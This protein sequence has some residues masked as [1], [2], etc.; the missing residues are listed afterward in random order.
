MLVVPTE[1]LPINDST[2]GMKYPNDTPKT[3]AKKI[4]RVKYLSRKL[5]LVTPQSWLVT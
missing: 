2:P 1:N 3:I 5:S 4:Q